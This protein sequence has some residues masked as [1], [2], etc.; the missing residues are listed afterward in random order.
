ML[1]VDNFLLIS[2]YKNKPMFVKLQNVPRS[3]NFDS[4]IISV[5][6]SMYFHC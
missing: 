6:S 4:F 5:Y 2:N 3:Y 1:F